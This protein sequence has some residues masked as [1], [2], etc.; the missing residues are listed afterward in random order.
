MLRAGGTDTDEVCQDGDQ[1]VQE[2]QIKT[3]SDG[4]ARSIGEFGVEVVGN[5]G[6]SGSASQFVFKT[7][8]RSSA[9]S[10]FTTCIIDYGGG[11]RNNNNKGGADDYSFY[12]GGTATNFFKGDTYIGGT[13]SRSTRE[14]WESTLTE[15]QKEQLTAGTLAIPANVSTPGDGSFARQWWYDQQSAEN[16]AL[17]DSGEL[18]YP[19]HFQAANFVDTFEL[20]VTTN[21]NLLANEGRG[22]FSGGVKVTGGSSEVDTGLGRSGNNLTLYANK[23]QG[24][25]I[26][27]VGSIHFGT[28]PGNSSD[29]IRANNNA[30][31]AT[32]VT[33]YKGV[34]TGVAGNTNIDGFAHYV[35]SAQNHTD[36]RHFYAVNQGLTGT[37]TNQYGYLA[38]SNLSKTAANPAATNNYGFFSELVNSDN[39]GNNYNFYANGSAPN[40]FAGDLLV[41]DSPSTNPSSSGSGA[42]LRKDGSTFGKTSNTASQSCVG[43]TR[44]TESGDASENTESRILTFRG[45][46]SNIAT[47]RF[48]GAG[49]V[50]NVVST[51]DYRTKENVVDMPSAVSAIK[52]LRPVEFN[53]INSPGKTTKGFIAHELQAVEPLAA[54]GTKDEIEAIGTHTDAEGV[55]ITDVTEPEALPYGETWVQTG[56]RPVYQSI[57][58][59][60]LIP[61]LTKALQEA[62]ERIEVLEAQVNS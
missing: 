35:N 56:T 62:L 7:R 44:R 61:L 31:N 28:G 59:T 50:T 13:T 1:I 24:V 38:N 48:D 9:Q 4:D 25:F 37:V 54:F 8:D 27:P 6:T 29:K 26:S 57:D 46:S 15:E 33:C 16:Q 10:P 12:A 42:L 19:S 2:Y 21:I 49:G 58:Q 36:I 40:Y 5:V 55:V 34:T 39:G 23:V 52:A 11:V 51:S 3:S 43:F 53:F 30:S 17:I 32:S 18:E 45:Q 47:I 22:E 14:L 20:G 60:K 41:A